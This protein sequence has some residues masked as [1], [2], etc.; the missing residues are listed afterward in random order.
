MLPPNWF[1]CFYD[2]FLDTGPPMPF[3]NFVGWTGTEW[4]VRQAIDWDPGEEENSFRDDNLRRCEM[5]D[6]ELRIV[7]AHLGVSERIQLTKA[8]ATMSPAE[9]LAEA[10]ASDE[11]ERRRLSEL[12]G[13]LSSEDIVVRSYVG[14][15]G[16]GHVFLANC[17]SWDRPVALKVLRPP[18]EENWIRRISREVAALHKLSNVEGVVRPT[19]ELQQMHGM[20]LVQ[21]EFIEGTPLS[22][23][24]LPVSVDVAWQLVSEILVVLAR[25]HKHAIIHRDLHLGNVMET[26]RGLVLIDFG[27]ARDATVSELYRTFT[28]VGTMS[29]CAPEK[30]QDPSSAGP[31][32]DVFSVGTMFYKLLTGKLPFWSD[33]YI[34]LYEQIKRCDFAPASSVVSSVPGFIDLVLSEMLAGNPTDRP[35]D[36]NGAQLLLSEVEPVLRLWQKHRQPRSR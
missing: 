30:W 28:P 35:Q 18:Y 25:V 29:H 17:A 4:E 27:L 5:T 12:L 33:T 11:W 32:S 6:Y 13:A 1:L 20:Y 9:L 31:A 15:G 2:E 26:P 14:S 22:Q 23:R 34:G 24:Q 36:A 8:V 19:S 7:L 10:A 21:T 3:V 16:C